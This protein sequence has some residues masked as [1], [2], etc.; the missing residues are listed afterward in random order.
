MQLTE[1]T[2]N[3]S[4]ACLSTE[5]SFLSKQYFLCTVNHNSLTL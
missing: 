3:P 1:N 5:Y 2:T 4:L